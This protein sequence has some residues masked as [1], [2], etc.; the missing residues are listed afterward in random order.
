M[1]HIY[2]FNDNQGKETM[3][4]KWGGVGEEFERG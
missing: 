2:A 3:Y 1:D 4:L